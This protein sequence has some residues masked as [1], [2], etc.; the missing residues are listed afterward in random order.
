MR[1]AGAAK[2]RPGRVAWLEILIDNRRT[3]REKKVMNTRKRSSWPN[4]EERNREGKEKKERKEKRER[5]E[6]IGITHS[7]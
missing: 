7:S 1:K 3:S 6:V 2:A 5:K 4:E